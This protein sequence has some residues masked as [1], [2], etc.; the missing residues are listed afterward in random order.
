MTAAAA[1][2]TAPTPLYARPA[3]RRTLWELESSSGH[4]ALVVGLSKDPNAKITV[5]LVSP[6]SERPV[7]AVKAPTTD[8]AAHA[9]AAEARL[10]TNLRARGRG[11][12]LATVPRVVEI[13][14]FEGREALVTTAVPGVPMSASY[15]RGRHT[16]DGAQVH[17]DFAA[18]RE[19]LARLQADTRGPR[20]PLEMDDDVS[21][22]LAR[23]FSD[24]DGIAE[25][26]VAL[27]RDE[28]PRTAVHVDLWFGNIL[29]ARGRVS[30]VVDWEAGSVSGEPV[31]DLV[32]FALGYALYLDRRTRPGRR[33]RGHRGLRAGAWGAGVEY[34]IEGHGWFPTLF[35][36][37]IQNG[38]ARL[39]ARRE[40]WRDAALAG[41]AEIAAV[42]DDDAFARHHFDLFR[43]LTDGGRCREENP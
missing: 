35:R 32:R 11:C 10:L 20:A 39:G 42:T 21:L 27:A 16:A 43:R 36:S 3:P 7:L 37:F 17:A 1:T 18:V 9:V 34:A 41:L 29:C 19:W 12:V 38:L 28:T 31:R 23:R 30:G 14:D 8:A 2:T 13:V 40:S 5:L 22:H 25:A 6:W 4:R 24:D 33:V 15:A 26:L